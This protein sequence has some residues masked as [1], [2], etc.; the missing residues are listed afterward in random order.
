MA[1]FLVPHSLPK[2]CYSLWRGE[3]PSPPPFLFLEP[4]LV[5]DFPIQ[6]SVMLKKTPESLLDCK[7]IT[8]VS[9][10]GNQPRIFIG[11]TNAE[12]EA[13]ILWPPDTKSKHIGKDPDAGKDWSQEKGTTEDDMVGWHHWFNGHEFGWT[14]GDGEGQGGLVCC[15]PWIRKESDMTERL[16]NNSNSMVRIT[17]HDFHS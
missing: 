2:L 12:A 10:K 1:I 13:A 7:Q 16:N 15:G 5:F 4:M 3:D 6:H 8:P 17:I 9:S 14:P 11:R